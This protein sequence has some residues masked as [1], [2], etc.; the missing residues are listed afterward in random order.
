MT[1]REIREPQ[2]SDW[3]LTVQTL[4]LS[5]FLFVVAPLQA[6]GFITSTMFDLLFGLVLIPGAVLVSG[7][8]T[9]LLLMLVAIALVVV[10][11]AGVGAQQ[12][13]TV[14]KF[15]DDL[16]WL[17]AGLTLGVVVAGTVFGPG[18][19]TFHRVVGGALLYLT[20][21]LVF[22]ALNAFVVL[23]DPNALSN[24][25]PSAENVPTYIYYSF[26]TLTTTGFGDIAPVHPFARGLANIEQVIGTLFPATL[27]ARL[28][29]LEIESRH[30]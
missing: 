15:L 10:V 16:A 11:A 26:T 19:I 8:R 14:D 22:V 25:H 9:A 21:G 18:K 24:L 5:V 6:S 17:I 4:A 20:I 3:L 1:A 28:V 13:P 7:N 2:L 29:T 12:V 23:L 30:L 27:L